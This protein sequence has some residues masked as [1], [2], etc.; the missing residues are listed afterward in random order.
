MSSIASTASP[1]S[2]GKKSLNKDTSLSTEYAASS[3]LYLHHSDNPGVI[4]VTQ[5]LL[6]DNYPTW[7]RAMRMALDAKNK[8]GFIDGSI[9]KPKD[10]STKF[11]QWTRCNSM[12]LSWIVNAL[13]PEISNS[14]IYTA[15]ARE[16][17]DDLR[18][19]FSQKNAPRIFEIC[20]AIANHTQG[21]SSIA[22]YYTV[23]KGYWDELSSYI[24]LTSCTCGASQTSMSHIQE[25]HLMQFLA[26]LNES[27]FGVRS[28]MLLQDPLPTVNRAYSLLLQDERQRSLQPVITTSLDQSAMA[29]NRSQSQKPFYHCKFCD[30]D[31]HSESRCRKNPASKNYMFCKFCDTAGHTESHC[32]KK[33]G[34]AKTNSSSSRTPSTGSFV[35]ATTSTPAAPTLTHEQ[36]TQLI[37]MLPSGKNNSMANVA[38]PEFEE[39]DW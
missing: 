1:K 12:V 36:Y 35:A 39:G 33:N 2:D 9:T 27:Y 25:E 37:A 17:W 38:R 22:S 11:H 19:R 13:S 6:G 32:K 7:S 26:G 4:L 20:R 14:V 34:T 23:F 21:N 16:V 31:D 10:V 28:N 30:A 8:L 18:E 29:A 5:P 3:P 24:S 15:T